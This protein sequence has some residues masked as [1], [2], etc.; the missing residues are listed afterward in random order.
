VLVT[1]GGEECS[2]SP[3]AESSGKLRWSALAHWLIIMSTIVAMIATVVVVFPMTT[4]TAGGWRGGLRRHGDRSRCIADR[5]VV[6]GQVSTSARHRHQRARH[7][8]HTGRTFYQDPSPFG[9]HAADPQPIRYGHTGQGAVALPE[10]RLAVQP[11]SAA[12]TLLTGG[13]VDAGPCDR[14]TSTSEALL[15]S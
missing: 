8:A 4:A 15:R 5:N 6:R 14:A 3:P 13:S 11:A 1:I 9:V 7:P 2:S 10:L 12:A